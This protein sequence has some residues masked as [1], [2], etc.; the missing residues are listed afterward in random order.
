[1]EK[2]HVHHCW[3]SERVKSVEEEKRE[4]VVG[5]TNPANIPNKLAHAEH[6]LLTQTDI[7]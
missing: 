6:M 1:M 2:F 4:E 7:P 3:G 5:G